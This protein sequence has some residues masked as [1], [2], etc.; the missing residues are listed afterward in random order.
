MKLGTDVLQGMVLMDLAPLSPRASTAV[1]KVGRKGAALSR[2]KCKRGLS[3]TVARVLKLRI[4][5][6]ITHDKMFLKLLRPRTNAALSGMRGLTALTELCAVAEKP[7]CNVA[8]RQTT[9]KQIATLH[10]S[11]FFGATAQS[12]VQSV[13]SFLRVLHLSAALVILGTFYHA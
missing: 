2:K 4:R 1:S 11:F 9:R 7:L 5:G 6:R 10:N 3:C 13:P 8:I 12:S